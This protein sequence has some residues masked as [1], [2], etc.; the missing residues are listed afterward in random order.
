M[1]PNTNEKRVQCD[2]CQE[3]QQEEMVDARQGILMEGKFCARQGVQ[4]DALAG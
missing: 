3:N 1:T 4:E 2:A